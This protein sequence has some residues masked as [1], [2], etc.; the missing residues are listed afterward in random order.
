[1][2]TARVAFRGRLRPHSYVSSLEKT[3]IYGGDSAQ[4]FL[5]SL[6]L[7][8]VNFVTYVL[9]LLCIFCLYLIVDFVCLL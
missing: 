5:L 4:T 1:M 7:P 3:L 9:F 8:L 6:T 2:R